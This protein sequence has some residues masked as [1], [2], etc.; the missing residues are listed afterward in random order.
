[1]LRHVVPQQTLIYCHIVRF[2]LT[3]VSVSNSTKQLGKKHC[4]QEITVSHL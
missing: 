2:L 3:R 1:M 4:D